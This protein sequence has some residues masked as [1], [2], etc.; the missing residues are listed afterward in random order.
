MRGRW[1][2]LSWVALA[3]VL[4]VALVIGS[5]SRP[6]PQTVS[7]RID[8]IAR[9]V[10]CP[11]CSGLSVAESDAPTA[12]AVRQLITDRV[13]A[14]RSDQNIESELVR[15]YGSGILLRPPATG[16]SAVVWAV[17]AGAGVAAVVAL[18]VVFRR[19]RLQA[20]SESTVSEEDRALVERALR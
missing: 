15:S 19:R 18:V 9:E 20:A 8:R 17:P 11:S 5:S 7:Q 2:K 1:L 16:V 10:R 13:K 6:G 4:V 3:T 14:G 12:V